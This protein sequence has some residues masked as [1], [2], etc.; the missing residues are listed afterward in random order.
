MSV[1]RRTLAHDGFHL[2]HAFLY[3]RDLQPITIIALDFEDLAGKYIALRR[4]ARQV[5]RLEAHV[6]VLI[7]EVWMA[8]MPKGGLSTSMKRPS[9]RLDRSE[10]LVVVVATSDG[11]TRSYYS[12][13]TRDKKGHPVLGEVSSEDASIDSMLSLRDLDTVWKRWRGAEKSGVRGGLVQRKPV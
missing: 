7:N 5:D 8:P 2:P 9:E 3:N 13:F 10:A 11:R 6:V 4:L 12:P 1:A